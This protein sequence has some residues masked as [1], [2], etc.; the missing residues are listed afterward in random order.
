MAAIRDFAVTEYIAASANWIPEMPVHETGD[1]LVAFLAKDSTTG[2][3]TSTGWTE[4]IDTAG[5]TFNAGCQMIRA[6]SA[7]EVFNVTLTSETGL[8]VIISVKDCFGTTLANALDL[9]PVIA[10]EDATIPYAGVASQSTT[11]DNCLVLYALAGDGGISPTAYQPVVNLFNGDATS[12]SLGVGYSFKKTAG[13]ISTVDW[14]GRGNDEARAMLTALRSSGSGERV[15]YSD[16]AISSSTMIRPLVGLS[17]MQS[18]SWPTSVSITALGEDFEANSVYVYE[19]APSYADDTTDANDPGTADVTWSQHIGDM[20]YFGNSTPFKSLSFITSTAGATGVVVWEY[21]S[22]STWT[23]APGMSGAFTATGGSRVAFTNNTPPTNWATNDPGMGQTKY[24]VRCRITTAYTTIVVQSQIRL[25]GYIASYVV[26]TASGDAGTNPY[27]DATQD[28]GAS[29]TT[30]L[31]GCQLNFGAAVDMDTG[32]I[33]G[34]FQG[35]L[36]R[37]FGVDIAKPAYNAGGIQITFFDTNNNLLSYKLGAKAAKSTLIDDRNVFA[38]DWNSAATQWAI[39]GAIDKSAVTKIH[40]TTYGFYGAAAIRWS[41]LVLMTRIGIA[42]GSSSVP[43]DLD[44]IRYVA[45]ASTGILPFIK[46]TGTSA[47]I[48]APLQF[49]GGD[50]VFVDCNLNSFQFPAVY[51]GTDNFDWN[52]AANVAGIKFYPKTGDSIK[53]TNSVFTSESAYRWEFDASS[54]TDATLN[55]SG[56][57]V[58]GA[59]VTLRNTGTAFDNMTFISCPTFTQNGATITNSAFTATK[60]DCSSP[61]NAALISDSSFI[62]TGTGHGIEIGGTAANMELTGVTFTG[63]AASDGSTG[64]EAIYVN[65]GSG[66]MSI[67]IDGGSAPSIRTA[68]ASI[69]VIAGAVSASVNVKDL[70]G[71]NIED[72]RVFVKAA[73]GGPFPFDVTVTIVNSGTTATVTHTTHAMATNDKVAISGASLDANNGVFTITKINDNSYSYTMG[74]SPGSSPTGTIKCTFVV[75]SGLTDA[76]GNITMSRVFPS[77]QPVTG[78]A[79][80][81]TEPPPFYKQ[82]AIGGSVDSDTGFSANAILIVDE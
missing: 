36:T 5:T 44:D 42:G 63:Y 29:S 27:T 16:P 38:I 32:I 45:N 47:L 53:F 65:I 71:A 7:A 1:V 68:G 19:I 48:Y 11:N 8:V 39:C 60:V 76:S 4:Y 34:T 15:P 50:P 33:M 26:A 54:A 10:T 49:G 13:T 82:S 28:A 58:I 12:G 24:W 66:S 51:D 6:T 3:S 17:T 74:S 52:C 57:S 18:D 20:M 72:A 21:W 79:R 37:D 80:K 56:T 46:Q 30:T 73:T 67:T 69:T 40:F 75:L 9:S 61:A 22:G 78:W 43:L 81:A 41:M 23:T 62:S 64:N 77:D 59:T 55:F 14:F 25:N 31:A 70:D 35:A 2:W